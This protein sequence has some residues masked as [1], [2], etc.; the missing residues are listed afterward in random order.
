MFPSL[1]FD[2]AARPLPNNLLVHG[3]IVLVIE[4]ELKTSLS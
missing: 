1:V 2:N 4:Q 3:G